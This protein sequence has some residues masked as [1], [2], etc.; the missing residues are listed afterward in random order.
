MF[1]L[2]S[3]YCVYTWM[4]QL[5][6]Q[7]QGYCHFDTCPCVSVHM[8]QVQKFSQCYNYLPTPSIPESSSLGSFEPQ[9]MCTLENW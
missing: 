6:G 7:F 9:K 3:E 2:I 1:E 4:T 8:S 5:A